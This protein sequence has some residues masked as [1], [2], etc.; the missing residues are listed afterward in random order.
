MQDWAK[1]LEVEHRVAS[2]MSRQARRGVYF[3]KK[4]AQWLIHVLTERILNID[5]VAVPQMP[6]MIHT[7][8]A[9]SKPFLKSGKPNAR[10]VALWE[11]L[12]EF[13]VSGP[14]T[15]IEY[16]QF[17]LGKT[18]RFKDW[19]LDQGWIPDQWNIKDITVGTD[20]KKLEPSRLNEQLN[21][22]IADLRQSRSGRL[23]MKIMG[24]RTGIDTIGDVKRKL[25]KMRKVLTTPKMTEESMDT[26]QGE[27][28]SLVMKRMVWSHRRSLLQ[29]LVAQVR[30]DGR[31]E[32][33]ANPCATPTGRMRHRVVVNIP[34]ARSPFGAEIRGLFQG[35]PDAVDAK[36][37]VLKKDIGENE[38]VR[39][40]TNIVEVFKGG[41]WKVAG[42]WKKHIPA[43]QLVFVGYDGAG[44]ELRMLAHYVN[45]PEYT[46]EIVDG[47][48]HTANQ[49]AAGL[50]T[51][52]DAKTFI[53]AFIYGAGDGKLGTIIGG[54]SKDGA[55]IR[56]KFLAAN[57]LLAQLIEDTKAEAARGWLLGIDGRKLVMRRSESGD[58]AVHKALNT[59]LQAAGAIVMKYAMEWLDARV[60]E[61]GLRA[62]KVLDIHDEGQWECHPDDV[63]ALRG[64]MNQC[65]AQA[66][67]DLGM[68]CPLASD[69]QIGSSWLDTH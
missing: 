40:F 44:L 43:N 69:S 61:M 15:A 3:N 21:N 47:D 9:F 67:I 2:I 1:A 36:G 51:R 35:T 30:P 8:G 66:G 7:A 39:P 16:K 11:R 46:R 17:D 56:A 49:L 45:D 34:A 33:S 18:A 4:K 58:V 50:P 37:Q 59:R 24:I 53:Y 63:P 20:G 5:L 68:N 29:G 41:K 23:R 60:T 64:L 22:Y 28:G 27:L 48:V 62:W 25:T 14:F 12:G 38:R 52:D 10:L 19:M 42:H 32:G 55:Q 13:E 26:V 31:L 54:T 57:P 6:Q 65:V